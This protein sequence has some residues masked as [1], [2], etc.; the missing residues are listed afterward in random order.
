MVSSDSSKYLIYIRRGYRYNV[1]SSSTRDF[2]II[3]REIERIRSTY[4][5]TEEAER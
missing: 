4:L 2:K 1:R 3:K 5:T